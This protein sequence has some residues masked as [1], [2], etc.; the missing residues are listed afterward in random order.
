MP[1]QHD[2]RAAFLMDHLHGRLYV[3]APPAPPRLAFL[4]AHIPPD[5]REAAD[6]AVAW[7]IRT[8][9]NEAT[10]DFFREAREA[11]AG[12]T[13]IVLAGPGSAKD[14]FAH[15]LAEQPAFRD[16]PVSTETTAWLTETAFERWAREQLGVPGEAATIFLREPPAGV[17]RR[18]GGPG[19]PVDPE[20]HQR[21]NEL[22]NRSRFMGREASD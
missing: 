2:R 4:P 13:R 22:K 17:H 14:E 3:Y 19:A 5:L 15:A 9:R 12:C 18:Q 11:L 20:H 7:M 16:V 1:S 21:T 10:R 6:P 8:D